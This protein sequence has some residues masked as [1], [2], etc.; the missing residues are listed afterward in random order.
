[1]E[2]EPYRIMLVP[3]CGETLLL[4]MEMK[5]QQRLRD[6]VAKIMTPSQLETAQ[7]FAR[8]CV[9]KNYKGC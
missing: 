6:L 4:R 3:I 5:M 7:K 9:R 2:R 1:M 8:E